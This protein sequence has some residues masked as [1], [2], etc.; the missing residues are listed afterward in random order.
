MGRCEVLSIPDRVTVSIES[1]QLPDGRR[2]D[3]YVQI[4]IPDFVLI[5]AETAA[6][7]VVWLRQYRHGA[8]RVSLELPSGQIDDAETP[9][10]AARRELLEETGYQGANWISLGSFVQSTSQRI[11]TGHVFRAQDVAIVR[12]PCSGDLEEARVEL[13][14]RDDLVAALHR[15]EIVSASCLAAIALAL[16]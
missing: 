15:N 13:L 4:D 9:L 16:L 6:G 8:R 5:F 11:G 1:V 12:E 3:D 14:T 10:E 7:E 2:V